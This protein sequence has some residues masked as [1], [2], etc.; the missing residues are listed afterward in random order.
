MS[1]DDIISLHGS[2]EDDSG[3][4]NSDNENEGE[5]EDVTPQKLPSPRLK[6]S[7]S[8]KIQVSRPSLATRSRGK[9]TL[10]GVVLDRLPSSR[11]MS[12]I[13]VVGP[14]PANPVTPTLRALRPKGKGKQRQASPPP[15]QPGP[16]ARTRSSTR[17]EL[18]TSVPQIA[19]P[20]LSVIGTFLRETTNVSLLPSVFFKLIQ[21]LIRL[22]FTGPPHVHSLHH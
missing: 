14:L 10:E 22:L 13:R 12:H 19:A 20:D 17:E 18:K 2:D 7:G 15:P 11:T 21:E 1:Q 16:S 5:V 6:E 3:D 8:S 9:A 4:D